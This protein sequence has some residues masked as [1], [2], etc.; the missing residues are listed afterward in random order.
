LQKCWRDRAANVSRRRFFV[1]A[2]C[3][4]TMT[5]K[6]EMVP[7]AVRR[8]DIQGLR[9]LSALLVVAFHVWTV[10]TAGAVDVFFVMSG[11]LLLGSLI[12]QHDANGAISL[13]RYAAGI[14]R[15]LLPTAMVVLVATIAVAQFLLPELQWNRAIKEAFASALFVENYALIHYQADYLA[16]GDIPTP[17][18]AAWAISTQVQAYALM[19]MLMWLVVRIRV[20]VERR[21]LVQF[22][23]LGSATVIS[24]AYAIWLVRVNQSVAY[25]STP[26]RLWEFTLGGLAAWMLLRVQIPERA[27]AAAGWLG[28]CMLLSTGWLLGATRM[29]PGWASIW[30]VVGA[31]LI[32]GAGAN[33]EV[34]GVGRVLTWRPL[35]WLGGISYGIYLWHGPIAVFT[36]LGINRSNLGLGGGL[37]VM[38]AAILFAALGKAILE[39]PL[40]RLLA[41]PIPIWRT[42]A[43]SGI[44][45]AVSLACVGGWKLREWNRTLLYR[46][47]MTEI[48][49]Q[50]AA[51]GPEVALDPRIPV[52]PR[53]VW[54]RQDLPD[55]YSERCQ[56]LPG[57][58]RVLSCTFG[59]ETSDVTLALVGGSHSA[60]WQPALRRIAERRGWRLKTYTKSACLFA[61]G[62][63]YSDGTAAPDCGAWNA[64]VVA[65][66]IENAPDLVITLGT[67]GSPETVPA[68]SVQQWRRL[69]DAGIGVLALRD[70]PWFPFDVPACIARHGH[71]SSKC[72]VSRP[73]EFK[74]DRQ[75]WPANARYA[76]T[77][78]WFCTPIE[79]R[80]VI[81]NILAYYDSNHLT[82]TF[83]RTLDGKLEPVVEQGLRAS[84]RSG[85]SM[86]AE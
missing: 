77:R 47:E 53:P 5:S 75:A 21:G 59:L 43:I 18:A 4:A 83:S 56:A 45:I 67:F 48:R 80:P 73:P 51:L 15:R 8:S 36:L 19:A 22:A 70:T 32:L 69:N 58:S 26:A 63:Y 79:C 12:R 10:R 81:G 30:P 55:V 20:P 62:S 42:Y 1:A 61:V 49:G 16:R 41:R 65:R 74:P 3:L 44:L 38:A 11:Y 64:S 68:G 39:V 2:Y 76:D 9:G 85:S 6:S 52:L 50:G 54:S 57:D 24:F 23:V 37:A 31:L 17:F 29:F 33:G 86:R 27:R 35:A 28:L 46:A 25:Y 40:S 84:A 7:P 78:D 66:L 71:D 14:L 60:Q 34:R 13:H 72:I 82:A